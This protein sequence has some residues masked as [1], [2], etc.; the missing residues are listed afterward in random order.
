MKHYEVLIEAIITE[1]EKDII[2]SIR[3]EYNSFEL[4]KEENI[5]EVIEPAFTFSKM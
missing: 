3:R 1:H 5:T 2:T 4:I